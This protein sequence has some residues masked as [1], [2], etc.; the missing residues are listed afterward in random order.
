MRKDNQE[1]S[2]YVYTV[3]AK[4]RDFIIAKKVESEN[5]HNAV[6]DFL[7]NLAILANYQLV[8]GVSILSVEQE[9]A[10]ND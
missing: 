4:Y 5:Q 3:K 9:V 10:E 8:D 2:F 1:I 7:K 6:I